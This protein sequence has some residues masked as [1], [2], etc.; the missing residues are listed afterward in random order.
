ME[1]EEREKEKKEEKMK[2]KEKKQKEKEQKEKEK[3]ERKEKKQKEKEQK[4]KERKE[5]KEKEQ[6]EKEK[7]E[8]KEK[9]QKDKEK[10]ERKKKN[11]KVFA[12]LLSCTRGGASEEDLDD[13]QSP[14][15]LD[16]CS[17][18]STQ[19]DSV[20]S[21]ESPDVTADVTAEAPLRISLKEDQTAGPSQGGLACSSTAEECVEVSPCLKE[22]QTAG[23][24]Q[25]GLTCSSTGEERV[26]ELPSPTMDEDKTAGPS[27]SRGLDR[28]PIQL[29]RRRGASGRKT[30][31]KTKGAKKADIQME[32][33]GTKITE[34]TDDDDDDNDDIPYPSIG[35]QI[36]FVM[37]WTTFLV[38]YIPLMVYAT[39]ELLQEMDSLQKQMEEHTVSVA[40]WTSAEAKLNKLGVHENSPRRLSKEEGECRMEAALGRL[41]ALSADELREEFAKANLKCGP[42]TATTRAI[43][44]RKLARALLET[45]G[46]S[47]Q[48]GS[49]TSGVAM[50]TGGAPAAPPSSAPSG[51]EGDVGYDLGLN[52]P[53]EEPLSDKS[54]TASA[55][56]DTQTPSKTAQTSPAFYYGVC[57][58][59][60]DVLARNERAHVY[61]D[62]KEALQ[63]VKLMKGA[64]FKAFSNREDAEKFA[65]GI[66]DYYP[67]PSKCA[68]CVSPVKVGLGFSKEGSMETDGINREKANSFKSPR[69][70]D[71][72]AKLRRAVEKG[73]EVAFSELVWSNPRYLIG[74]GDNPTV[75][76]EG[77]RYNVMHVAAKENQAGVAQ[78]LLDILENPEFM[79]LMYPDDEDSMLH[80]RIQYI[81]DLY[82]NT[83]DKASFETPLHFACKF[84]CAAVVNVLCSHPDI[85]K[86]CKNKYDQRPADCST[87]GRRLHHAGLHAHRPLPRLSLTPRHHHQRLQWCRTRLSWRDSERQ[88]VIF[89]DESRFSLGGDAQRIRVWRH[90]G[91]HR[92]EV[93][94]RPEGLVSLHLHPYRTICRNCV[95]MFKLHGMDYHRTPLGTST[96]P[97][98]DVWRVGLA[99]TAARR[100]TER[101]TSV[102]CERMKDK[103]K[104]QEVRQKICEYLEVCVCESVCV[105]RF[106]VPLLR[107]ADNSSQPVIGAPWSPE[108]MENRSPRLPRSP[109]DPVMT[110]R[111][112]A[113]PLSP[114]KA[115]EFRRAWKTPPRERA[116]HFH[117][118]WKSDP[119]RGAERV[120]RDL[121]RELGHPWAE[122][123]DFLDSFV[124][125]ASADGL[126]RLEEFL[127]K[128]DFSEHAHQEAGENETSNKFRTPSPG[129]PKKFSNSVSVGAFL[130]EGTDISLEEI[131]NRQNAA[132]T[133][134]SKDGQ[135]GATGGLEFHILP[136]SH[137]S[138]LI[139]HE[140][141]LSDKTLNGQVGEDL[142]QNG[143]DETKRSSASC[144]LSPISNLMVEFERMSLRDKD[145]EESPRERRRSGGRRPRDVPDISRLSLDDGSVFI[146]G[147][148]GGAEGAELSSGSSEEYF[149]AEEGEQGGRT[150]AGERSVCARSRSWDH[151]SSAS[152]A[153][154]KSFDRSNELILTTP[155][156]TRKSLFIE[157]DSPTKLDRE[158]LSAVE[159]VEI[160]SLKYPSI[161]KWKSTIQSYSCAERQS[162]PTPAVL[163]S[164]RPQNWTPGSPVSG[165]VSPAGRYSPARHAYSPDCSS[166]G[167]YSPAHSNYSPAHGSHSPASYI[168]RIR[169]KH[170]GDSPI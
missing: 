36:F 158:V 154:Y 151:C 94:T 122:Y 89:S 29:L 44:E 137:S 57:P 165:L 3:R 12:L 7:R 98:R 85:D 170:F 23:P 93:V 155:P 59:W 55:Q 131:K 87:I 81:T 116:G 69:T 100:H 11:R 1:K 91:Q 43:F 75:V 123:W 19:D 71:L 127:S 63:A 25:G 77:C 2:E 35:H 70:Q 26:E 51:E 42:I 32:E 148:P 9:K 119:D 169:L 46:I 21:Q 125:L 168:Q 152:S 120:G 118:I 20:H 99:N 6:K 67:S 110:V 102:I 76:Q 15:P 27:H 64:R 8:R 157:G 156:R 147:E 40:S 101:Q 17:G 139:E 60:E 56:P 18:P 84:G 10:N 92:D 146:G 162:W 22:D 86:N 108:P 41:R 24:S 159:G 14:L 107:A 145:A 52:P 130:D 124:D 4:E 106:Y 83:P 61:T 112:F 39:S 16:A 111:A 31:I 5:K 144:L 164:T 121:A 53:E 109:M 66:C 105:Y 95:R 126:R 30:Q 128:K 74:S 49:V 142:T 140:L 113:G 153:S 58:L 73:D 117:H 134:C 13:H 132:L 28:S 34:R 50:E 136:V 115:D 82:L 150:R 48:D 163:K 103:S 138:T 80:K 135:R 47:E 149:L 160:D 37:S 104:T 68:P 97:Y 65:K 129:K 143:G 114:S 88:R 167:R 72:T 96:A 33:G 78:L 62:K 133:S 141:L 45:A 54:R 161:H 90:R 166:P 79:R 38:G